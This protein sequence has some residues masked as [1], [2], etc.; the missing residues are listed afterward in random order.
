MLTIFTTPKAFKG[1]FAII[2][3]NAIA[4][5]CLL[6]PKCQIILIGNDFGTAKIARKYR[7]KNIEKVARNK[8]GTPLL[9]DIFERA[10]ENA[11][12]EKL[13]YINCDIIL[14]NDFTEAVRKVELPTFFL[15]G[16]RW[17]FNINT[18]LDFS[19]DWSK[20]LKTKVSKEGSQKSHGPTDYFVF[21]PEINFRIP[22]LAV[23]RTYWDAWLIFRAKQ[24]GLPVID[25]TPTIWAIHQ[26]HNYSHAGGW[27]NVWLGPESRE[28]K[29]LIGDRRKYFNCRDADYLLTEDGLRKSKMTFARVIRKIETSSVLTP[30][31]ALFV[32]P[33]NFII[34]TVKFVRDKTK[35][36]IFLSLQAAKKYLN[37]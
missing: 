26:T 37:L 29:K 24:L 9:P 13:A 11:Q 8:F 12:F 7:L 14:T 25:A 16:S 36:L 1:Q 23:G 3:E 21:T 10:Y 32:Y 34:R 22:K 20:R 28:N 15:T 19:D 31:L 18:K 33:A 30:K 27:T 17:E 35:L 2:Q 6:R 5:W 4:S